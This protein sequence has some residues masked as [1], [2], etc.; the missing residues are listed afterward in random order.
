MSFGKGWVIVEKYFHTGEENLLSILSPR[1]SSDYVREYM[2]QRYVDAFASFN[3]KI[4]YKKKKSSWPYTVQPTERLYHDVLQCG[5][6]PQYLAA[7]CHKL[8]LKGDKLEYNYQYLRGVSADD[9]PIFVELRKVC[10]TSR[11]HKISTNFRVS[12]V[13][14]SNPRFISACRQPFG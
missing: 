3:E 8:V 9:R 14:R 2:E 13:K 6:E 11:F 7:K 5:H 1:N 10:T 12:G 4:A